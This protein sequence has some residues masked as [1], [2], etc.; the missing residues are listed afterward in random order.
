MEEGRLAGHALIEQSRAEANR[1]VS[2]TEIVQQAHQ[3]AQEIMKQV[4]EELRR[5]R[6]ETDEYIDAR[7]ANFEITLNRTLLAVK[8]GRE[9][10]NGNSSFNNQG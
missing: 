3:R 9:K 1:L 7:L 8:R 4:D 2:Q 5:M 6:N 10:I